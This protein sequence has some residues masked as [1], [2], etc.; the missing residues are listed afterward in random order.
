VV[1]FIAANTRSAHMATVP[2]EKRLMKAQTRLTMRTKARVLDT[3]VVP[4]ERY[5]V[6]KVRLAKRCLVLQ[7]ASAEAAMVLCR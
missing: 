4:I 6:I 5:E 3:G 2:H 1:S 7:R